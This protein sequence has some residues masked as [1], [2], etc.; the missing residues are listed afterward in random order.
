GAGG[1][2]KVDVGVCY[3]GMPPLGIE[4]VIGGLREDSWS[5]VGVDR[6]LNYVLTAKTIFDFALD[7]TRTQLA[8]TN[9]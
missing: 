9:P 8:S 3:K 4:N 5:G 2:L 7:A 6:R 1:V